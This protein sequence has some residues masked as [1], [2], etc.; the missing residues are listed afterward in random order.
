MKKKIV[1]SA[2]LQDLRY[3]SFICQRVNPL[4]DGIF[5]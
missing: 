4:A 1:L 3:V 5:L 2:V